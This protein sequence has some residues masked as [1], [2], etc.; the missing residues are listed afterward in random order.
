MASLADHASSV[1]V[2]RNVAI[3]LYG[4]GTFVLDPAGHPNTYNVTLFG[5]GDGD[6]FVSFR[7]TTSQEGPLPEPEARLALV[8]D[9]DGVPDSYGVELLLS[10]LAT[11]PV[12]A[13]ARITARSQDG[14]ALSFDAS[15]APGCL[16]EGTV[17][18]DGPDD[19]GVAAAALGEAPFTYQVEVRL[20]GVRYTATARWPDDE[21]TGNEPSVALEFSPPLPAAR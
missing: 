19:Q 5:E 11:T 10:N 14:N 15:R 1:D 3:L 2:A 21:I 17:Y 7:W 13:T 20:D 4:D 8:A 12:E 9:H 16:A 18:W 6:L